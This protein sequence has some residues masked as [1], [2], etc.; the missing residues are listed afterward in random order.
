MIPGAWSSIKEVP[1]CFFRS[2]IK[3]QGHT[4]WKS[5]IWIQWVRLLGRLQLSNP[6]D[7]PWPA[8]LKK[9]TIEISNSL[10]KKYFKCWKAMSFSWLFIHGTLGENQWMVSSEAMERCH[11][12]SA[13]ILLFESP[14]T[15]AA[16]WL[17]HCQS[18]YL[19]WWCILLL[20]IFIQP[21][22]IS[23]TISQQSTASVWFLHSPFFWCLSAA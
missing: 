2:S 18:Q 7:L 23:I 13:L 1:Y 15:Q 4:G 19:L 8:S 12:A 10:V 5:M 9:K 20:S 14:S 22:F 16:Q 6:S 17:V 21:K 11:I 3:F